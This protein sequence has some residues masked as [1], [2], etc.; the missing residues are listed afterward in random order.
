MADEGC[1]AAHWVH[2][3][4]FSNDWNVW[5]RVSSRGIHGWV[6][7]CNTGYLLPHHSL[8]HSAKLK[9]KNIYLV[10]VS[11]LLRPDQT[12][13]D[14]V[15]LIWRPVLIL[16]LFPPGDTRLTQAPLNL[17]STDVSSVYVADFKVSLVDNP[18]TTMGHSNPDNHLYPRGKGD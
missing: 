18:S 7:S 17:P 12:P 6:I 13:F 4:L 15:A 16:R 5:V 3:L 14:P 9:G 10:K 11:F 1:P 2:H 8:L